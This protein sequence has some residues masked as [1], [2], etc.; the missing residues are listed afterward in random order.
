MKHLPTETSA[1][2]NYNNVFDPPGHIVILAL[3]AR[4][5]TEERKVANK[6]LPSEYSYSRV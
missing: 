2:F 1:V 6:L 5:L 3:K 4:I